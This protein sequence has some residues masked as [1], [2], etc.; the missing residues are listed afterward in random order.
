[1]GDIL[2]KNIMSGG[3]ETDILISEGLISKGF[4]AGAEGFAVE[5]N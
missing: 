5:S 1:M 2:L 3:I 4:P